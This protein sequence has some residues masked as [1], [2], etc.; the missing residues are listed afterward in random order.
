MNAALEAARDLGSPVI[1][2]FSNGGAQF[3]AGKGLDNKKQEASI[4]GAV[5]GAHFVRAV[6]P[7]YGIPVIG[8]SLTRFCRLTFK[9]TLTIVPKSC[10]LGSMEC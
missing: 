3:F 4:L 9:S 2:Q 6:A 8:S 7:A 5:A 10:S 1:I